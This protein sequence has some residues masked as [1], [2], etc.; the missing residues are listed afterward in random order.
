LQR[1][2]GGGSSAPCLGRRYAILRTPPRWSVESGEDLA[3]NLSRHTRPAT[4]DS[5]SSTG[6]GRHTADA[7]PVRRHR[8][9]YESSARAPAK[10]FMFAFI[11]IDSLQCRKSTY[12]PGVLD[13][14]SKHYR[15]RDWFGTQPPN[16]RPTHDEQPLLDPHGRLALLFDGLTAPQRLDL[17]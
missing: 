3:F 5:K 15:I 9:Q 16:G 12:S 11:F 6:K 14:E 13:V 1:L 10:L 4:C 2:K 8:R 7:R 17:T